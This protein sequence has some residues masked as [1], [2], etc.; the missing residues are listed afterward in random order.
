MELAEIDAWNGVHDPVIIIVGAALPAAD[1]AQAH[2]VV[3][4]GGLHQ[5]RHVRGKVRE[6]RSQHLSDRSI[7]RLARYTPQLR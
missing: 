3:R 1:H 6:A 7:P 2:H 5:R 4:I